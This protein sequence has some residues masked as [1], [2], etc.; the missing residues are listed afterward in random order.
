MFSLDKISDKFK[1]VKLE[2]I[3]VKTDPND[4]SDLGKLLTEVANF[5]F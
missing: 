1:E 4:E 5:D 2:N 3:F